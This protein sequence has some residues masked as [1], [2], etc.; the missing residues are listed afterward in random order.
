M[1]IT[2]MASEVYIIDDGH[3]SYYS[4][5]QLMAMGDYGGNLTGATWYWPIHSYSSS[6]SAYSKI[7]SSYG[8]RGGSYN[9]YHKGVD[10]GESLGTAVYSIRSGTVSV[11]DNS[12][13][14][15]EG[16][17]I[18]IDHNDGYWSVY[19]HLSSINV[20]QGQ[21]VTPN[22]KIGAVGGSGYN[23]ENYY[24]KHLHLGIHY[25]N[26]FDWECNVNPCPSGYTRI[27]NSLQDSAGGYP[28]GS[29][30]IAYSFN[31]DD[32]P[33]PE[34]PETD[35]RPVAPSKVEVSAVSGNNITENE[36]FKISWNDGK[37]AT[38][39]DICIRSL[40]TKNVVHYSSVN[41]SENSYTYNL[42]VGQYEVA[43][44]TVNSDFP[45]S[46]GV[47]YNYSDYVE[48]EVKGNITTESTVTKSGAKLIIDIK[49]HNFEEP[50][51]IFIVGYK[52]NQFVTMKR[53]PYNELNSPYTL[54]G[55]IDKIKV[56]VWDSINF[57]PLCEAEAITEDEFLIE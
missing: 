22:T 6:S 38:K 15:S 47:N 5:I 18:I 33:T 53:V 34:E 4:P 23:R 26:S 35:N 11:V 31:F 9:R 10:I 21:S 57:K 19:M 2:V 12:T 54:D 52:G 44:I 46:L 40:P 25:G 51:D 1:N 8:F 43:V 28:I 3:E 55:N 37:N 20:K 27:G 7:T 32:E 50:Y 29:A 42:P 49:V 48:F 24:P 36:S 41:S 30:S 14:G 16:R 13:G 56:M 39:Y 45:T 17:S